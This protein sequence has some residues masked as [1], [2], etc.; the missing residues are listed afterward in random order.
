MG[1]A[2]QGLEQFQAD[3]YAL[4]LSVQRKA[5]Q[6]AVKGGAGLIRA[7]AA[8][9][10]LSLGLVLTGN[11]KEREIVT[12]VQSQSNAFSVI[13]RIGPAQDAFYGR[14]PEFGTI[15]EP[16][17]PFLSPAFEAQKGPALNL[18]SVILKKAVESGPFKHR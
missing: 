8:A 6:D 2:I 16:E 1:E 7:A 18:A 14:F 4:S 10:V 17:M 3:L 11:L 9:N 15:F 12:I 13:A 5:L